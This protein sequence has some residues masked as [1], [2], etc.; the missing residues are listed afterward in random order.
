MDDSQVSK[1]ANKRLIVFIISLAAFMG[2][3]DIT[4]VNISLPTISRYF[5][6]STGVVSWVVM[7]YLLVLSSFL[8][9]FGKLADIKGYKKVFITGFVL[10]I[11][12]SFLCGIAPSIEMLIAFRILQAIGAAMFTA[13]GP[14]M[15]S[16]F[17]PPDIRGRA[18]GYVTTLAALGIAVGPVV[19]G[20]LTA[21]LSWR[22]IFF[23]NVPVGICATVIALSILPEH[24]GARRDLPF[25]VLGAVLIFVALIALIFGL[26]MGQ[27]K[28]WTSPLIL[29]SFFAFLVSG[30]AFTIRERKLEDPLLDLGFFKNLNFDFANGAA[31]LVMMV[32]SGAIF[33]LPF[34][35]ELVKDIPVNVAGLI[36]MI[37]PLAMMITGPIAGKISDRRG[38]RVICILTTL[39]ASVAFFMASSFSEASSLSFIFITLALAGIAIGM[40]IPPNSSLILGLSPS[41]KQG[42]ASSLMMT[43]RDVGSVVGIAAFET[44]FSLTIHASVAASDGAV[45]QQLSTSL[46]TSGFHDAFMIGVLFCILALVFSILAKDSD[47]SCTPRS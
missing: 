24:R 1:E 38:P 43:M 35:L 27:E 18:L 47:L 17:L 22:W 28:S 13:I 2:S 7:V 29:A 15:V 37:P 20:Y 30:I 11:T 5:D 6:V 26:N 3:L 19:G 36:L 16:I 41:D 25:D 44:V 23:V 10:F 46:L 8:L 33:L 32:F 40:F 45:H 39:L 9:A 31:F 12:G 14:A 34:Y 4:I 21:Y 42:V